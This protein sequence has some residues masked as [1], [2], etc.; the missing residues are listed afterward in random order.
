MTAMSPNLPIDTPFE[1]L[2]IDSFAAHVLNKYNAQ[3]RPERF[4]RFRG[5]S[6]RFQDPRG[7][8]I[9][10][11]RTR[12]RNVVNDMARLTFHHA[13][14][15]T[16]SHADFVHHPIELCWPSQVFL[17]VKDCE[18][19]SFHI[20]LATCFKVNGSKVRKADARNL[21]AKLAENGHRNGYIQ[22]R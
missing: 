10:S 9:R 22:A 1:V 5:H 3:S 16:H 11:H 21:I 12:V 17:Q 19:Q 15:E 4:A 7:E 20:E 18:T 14:A 8:L 2:G 13:S 6:F